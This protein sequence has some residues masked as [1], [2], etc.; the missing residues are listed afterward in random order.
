MQYEEARIGF[1][2]GL[3]QLP[4]VAGRQEAMVQ[5][6]ISYINQELQYRLALLKWMYDAGVL[7][8]RFLGLPAME[9]L[10][11]EQRA[12]RGVSG[13]EAL[14]IGDRRRGDALARDGEEPDKPV[15][16]DRPKPSPAAA[17]GANPVKNPAKAAP[18]APVADPAKNPAKNPAKAAPAA[19]ARQRQ[20]PARPIGKPARE[21]QDM[22]INP[23][24]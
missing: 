10:K 18:E 23:T 8:E 3:E 5:A 24:L 4:V 13:N 1:E 16:Q 22:Q 21:L 12:R 15:F 14:G 19:P 2:N 9:I 7:Q 6:E 11:Q 20:A 17:P